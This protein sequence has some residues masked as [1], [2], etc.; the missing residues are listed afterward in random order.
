MLRGGSETGGGVAVGSGA[1]GSEAWLEEK[2]EK[3]KVE[4]LTDWVR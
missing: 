3:E 4:V 2:G 1:G